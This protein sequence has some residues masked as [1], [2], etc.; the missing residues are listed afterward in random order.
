MKKVP[1][2]K[3]PADRTIGVRFLTGSNFSPKIYT[4]LIAKRHRVYLGQE[5]VVHNHIG[6]CIVV[7]ARIDKELDMSYELKRITLQVAPL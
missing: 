1:K 6:S 3:T 5:L 2:R 4:Y 7:V